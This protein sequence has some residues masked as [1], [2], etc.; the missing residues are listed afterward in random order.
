MPCSDV[1]TIEIISGDECIGDSLPK[2]NNNFA[3]LEG[4]ACNLYTS[5][6]NISTVVTNISSVAIQ[7]NEAVFVV[8]CSDESSN[9][10]VNP[11][12]ATFHMPFNM[13]LTSVK[14]TVTTPPSGSSIIVD[15]RR[16]GTS[17][18]TSKPTI[19]ANQDISGSSTISSP[20][21]TEG[22]RISFAIESVG[23]QRAGTGLKVTLKGDRTA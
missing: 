21:L 7:A 18:L 8:A 2:I 4:A 16:N 22:Q 10:T 3:K 14:A 11:S 13:T 19:A 5:V 1:P 9:L 17:V 12:A 20:S 6:T 23:S 15:V